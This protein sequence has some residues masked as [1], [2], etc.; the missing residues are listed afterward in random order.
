MMTGH[1]LKTITLNEPGQVAYLSGKKIVIHGHS[2]TPGSPE[3]I[4]TMKAVRTEAMQTGT[5]EGKSMEPGMGGRWALM[6]D[7][8]T[9]KGYTQSQA[10]A[11]AAKAKIAKYGSGSIH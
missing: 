7:E 11:I 2:Y 9:A 1:E 10:E 8:L 4:K 5:Y 3:A 6:V